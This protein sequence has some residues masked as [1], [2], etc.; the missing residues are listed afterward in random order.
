MNAALKWSKKNSPVAFFVLS[1]N[2]KWGVPGE[3]PMNIVS[4]FKRLWPELRTYLKTAAT[5]NYA[6]GGRLRTNE[7]EINFPQNQF[8]TQINNDFFLL[9]KDMS[10]YLDEAEDYEPMEAYCR[11]MLSLFVWSEEN[12]D[13][14]K[15]SIVYSMDKQERYEEAYQFYNSLPEKGVLV[16]SMYALSVLA[17]CDVERAEEILDPYR[18]STDPAISDRIQLLNRLKAIKSSLTKPLI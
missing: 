6:D 8:K 13:I 10:K 5:M 15:G 2:G 17:R 4:A 18:D 12:R 7:L 11:D 3:N 1:M 9:L 16:A 14:W